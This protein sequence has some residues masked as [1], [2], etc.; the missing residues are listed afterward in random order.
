MGILHLPTLEGKTKK[1]KRRRC[2]FGK[3]CRLVY[4]AP[5]VRTLKCQPS[6]KKVTPP[7]HLFP[8]T[9]RRTRTRTQG[10][11]GN[12]SQHPPPVGYVTGCQ[13]QKGEHVANTFPVSAGAI[14]GQTQSLIKI[15]TEAAA[16]RWV[17]KMLHQ[18]V[19]TTRLSPPTGMYPPHAVLPHGRPTQ[20]R[21]SFIGGAAHS[22]HSTTRSGPNPRGVIA[23][24]FL[25]TGGQTR[26]FS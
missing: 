23:I 6:V 14:C 11:W 17:G 2:R 22:F 20:W 21:G 24:V 1:K 12:K 13:L 25:R 26:R 10:R 18:D 4:A 9:Y 3:V 19:V 15:H 16:L 7:C 5:C 8:Y